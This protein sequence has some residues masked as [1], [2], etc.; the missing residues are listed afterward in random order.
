MKL[1]YKTTN[2]EVHNGK[3][4]KLKKMIMKKNSRQPRPTCQ[5][6]DASNETEI[7]K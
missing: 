5:T 1:N 7:N 4:I 2:V 6:C 3:N